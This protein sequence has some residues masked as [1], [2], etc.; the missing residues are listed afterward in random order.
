MYQKLQSSPKKLVNIL[1]QT[2]GVFEIHKICHACFYNNDVTLIRQ[3]LLHHRGEE[4]RAILS[5]VLFGI[6]MDLKSYIG[7]ENYA[8]DGNTGFLLLLSCMKVNECRKRAR[9]ILLLLIAKTTSLK[10]YQ[11]LLKV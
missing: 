6:R 4:L 5:S 11:H 3:N 2:N 9:K 10:N 7:R 1:S 8:H